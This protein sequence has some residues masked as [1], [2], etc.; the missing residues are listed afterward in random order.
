MDNNITVQRVSLHG[1]WFIL[2]AAVLWGTSGAV[3]KVIYANEAASPLGVSLMRLAIATPVLALSCWKLLGRDMFAIG[4]RDLA[5]MAVSGFCIACSHAAYFAAIPYIGLTIATLVTICTA[6]IIVVGISTLLKQEPLTR[7]VFAALACALVGTVALVG[8]QSDIELPQ[9]STVGVLFAL[10][11]AV[12]YAGM[13]VCGRFLAQRYHSLQITTIQFSAGTLVSLVFNLL[14]GTQ[15]NFSFASWTLLLYLGIMTTAV[16]YG[17]FL[18][19]MKTTSGTTASI[20]TVAEPLTAAFIAW[21]MFGERLGVTG[22]VGALLLVL[23][24]MI[25]AYQ[26][27]DKASR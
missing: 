3:I 9:R 25:L 10:G 17:L 6:P 23:S 15:F 1:F 2:I 24:F 22:L 20:L 16:A 11:S 7:R 12:G 5:L 19:G 4:R 18:A 27:N 14:A 21:L 13:I 8:L 26:A